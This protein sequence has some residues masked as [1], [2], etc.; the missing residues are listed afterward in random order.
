MTERARDEGRDVTAA[1][2]AANA[3]LN[4]RPDAA[5]RAAILAAAARAVDAGPRA[6]G[7]ARWR[8]WRFPL[9]AAAT[10]L[11][12][13]V[14]F[15]TAQRIDE[16]PPTQVAGAPMPAAPAPTDAEAPPAKAATENPSEGPTRASRREIAQSERKETEFEPAPVAKRHAADNEAP[17]SPAAAAAPMASR[18]AADSAGDGSIE[19]A[20]AVPPASAPG[21]GARARSAAEDGQQLR[22]P[23]AA[24]AA[25]VSPPPPPSVAGVRE[26]DEAAISADQPPSLRAP[27]AI[28]QGVP[29]SGPSADVRLHDDPQRWL[30]HVIALR[31]SGRDDEADEELKR[32]RARYPNVD[33]PKAALRPR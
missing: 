11:V 18:L 24:A 23:Q 3:A 2:R 33:V 5:T 32:L 27:R 14:A 15:I 8:Q 7:A 9:A 4:E 12:S 26:A 19:A 30:E 29:P 13:T 6:V 10:L 31:K 22:E 25:P 28:T 17:P 20:P 1:Y 16:L 21:A